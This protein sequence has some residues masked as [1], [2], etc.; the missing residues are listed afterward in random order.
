MV[1]LVQEDTFPLLAERVIASSTKHALAHDHLLRATI[2]QHSTGRLQ[3]FDDHYEVWTN[4]KES[5]RHYVHRYGDVGFYRSIGIRS[6]PLFDEIWGAL[7]D[8]RR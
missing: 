5:E 8:Y 1:F 3:R 2:L 6:L 7:R 4:E